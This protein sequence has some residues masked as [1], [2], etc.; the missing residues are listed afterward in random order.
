MPHQRGEPIKLR[1]DLQNRLEDFALSQL[2]GG[3]NAFDSSPFAGA[4]VVK[5]FNASG[6][7]IDRDRVAKIGDLVLDPE[8][9]KQARRLPCVNVEEPDFPHTLGRIAIAIEPVPDGKLGDF[10]IGGYCIASVYIVKATDRFATVDPSDPTRL[11]SSDTGEVRIV[12]MSPSAADSAERLCFIAFGDPH[13]IRWRYI[14]TAAFSKAGPVKILRI[15]GDD[16]S[17]GTTV[18]LLDDI[19]LMDDQLPNDVGLM[20]QIG[21]TFLAV[22][23][24]CADDSGSE[25]F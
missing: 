21:D 16:F 19:E 2:T 11:R 1:A 3:S 17:P 7:L 8:T 18:T 6:D 24:P 23:A 25:S 4:V 12:S 15:D 10:A 5:G 13:L 14:R 9:H 22:N 20:D